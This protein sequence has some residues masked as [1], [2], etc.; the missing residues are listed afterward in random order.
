MCICGVKQEKQ[1]ITEQLQRPSF[2][3]AKI[4]KIGPTND[5]ISARGEPSPIF[6]VRRADGARAKK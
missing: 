5:K 4:T 6:P 1:R 2:M 3:S